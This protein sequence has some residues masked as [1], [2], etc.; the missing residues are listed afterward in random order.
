MSSLKVFSPAGNQMHQERQLPY[1][2]ELHSKGRHRWCKI[3]IPWLGGYLCCLRSHGS[4]HSRDWLRPRMSL[5]KRIDRCAGIVFSKYTICTGSFSHF[6]LWLGF[7]RHCRWERRMVSWANVTGWEVWS[8]EPRWVVVT[9]EWELEL[10]AKKLEQFFTAFKMYSVMAAT[11]MPLTCFCPTYT[12]SQSSMSLSSPLTHALFCL[13]ST[14]LHSNIYMNFRS[15]KAHLKPPSLLTQYL[16]EHP[17]LTPI[18]IAT[19][20]TSFI[21]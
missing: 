6:S 5:L 14:W 17:C 8:V 1:M 2:Y 13:Q 19:Y 12:Y 18:S 4:S 11:G 16:A 7:A 21:D 15:H 20:Y 9:L 10:T 3:S